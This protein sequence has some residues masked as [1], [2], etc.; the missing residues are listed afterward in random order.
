MMSSS[1]DLL[2]RVVTFILISGF[3]LVLLVLLILVFSSAGL[4]DGFVFLAIPLGLI[5]GYIAHSKGR[6]FFIW[7]LY[8]FA[9]FIV[10]LPHS[11]VMI[12]SKK[13]RKCPFCESIVDAA[14]KICNTCGREI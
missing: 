2:L 4:D 12:H 7:W 5:P 14:S 3:S 11:I 8:G 9:I 1:M 13:H 6:N 10:A